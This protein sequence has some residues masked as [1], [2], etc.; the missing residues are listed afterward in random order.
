VLSLRADT[1]IVL[2]SVIN[3]PSGEQN[4][5]VLARRVGLSVPTLEKLLDGIA[6]EIDFSHDNP[7]WAYYE[8][9]PE[10]RERLVQDRLRVREE[11]LT[12]EDQELLAREDAHP[13]LELFHIQVRAF[14]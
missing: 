14:G 5:S 8:L 1:D 13:A 3:T 6:N 4:L 2:E 10:E 11:L 12:L 7:M 9:T